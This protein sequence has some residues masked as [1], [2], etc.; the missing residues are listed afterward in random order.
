MSI[1]IVGASQVGQFLAEKLSNENKDVILIERDEDKLAMIDDDLDVQ[2]IS[3]NGVSNTLL[4]SAGVEKTEMLIAVTDSDETNLLSCMLANLHSHVPIKVARVRNPEF[5]DM[6]NEDFLKQLKI[7]KLINPDSETASAI[8]RILSV[9]GSSDVLNFFDG[10]MLLVGVK[11]NEE[12]QVVGKPLESLSVFRGE[13]NVL[14][15]AIIRDEHTIIP[16]GRD[17]LQVGDLVYFA[18]SSYDAEYVMHHFGSKSP[19]I[20]SVMINGGNYIGLHLAEHLEKNNIQVK[21]VESDNAICENLIKK[22]NKSVVL[23]GL[24][25]DQ[26]T[27]VQENISNM[28][29]FISVTEDDE[30]NVLSSLLA[31]QLGVPWTISRITQPGYISLVTKIGV[32]VC[33]NPRLITE[34]AILHF[35]RKGKVLAV[36][37][38]KEDLEILEIEAV[39]AS[40]IVNVPL[41]DTKIPEGTL[42]IAL[43]RNGKILIPHGE[44]VIEAGDRVLIQTASNVIPKVEDLFKQKTRLF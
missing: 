41:K 30:D 28:D 20:K 39:E 5:L 35:I 32:D 40:K 4:K 36:S 26:S 43:E 14:L 12:T 22:L 18:A 34:S 33:V 38:I 13:H 42:I 21:I 31:K 17:R 37:S 10:R 19:E 9:P 1:I 8:L 2:I 24:G 3:G 6:H 23:N 7:D 15:T 27:L 16:S 25:T 44:S 11:I 29:A